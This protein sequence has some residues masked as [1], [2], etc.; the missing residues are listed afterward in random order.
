MESM[1][2][3]YAFIWI[4]DTRM[5]MREQKDLSN[6]LKDISEELLTSELSASACLSRIARI[7]PVQSFAHFPCIHI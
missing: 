2:T 1:S 7:G 6:R 5:I 3:E 4:V